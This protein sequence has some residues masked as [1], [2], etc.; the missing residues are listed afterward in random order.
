[1]TGT[2]D[3]QRLEARIRKDLA[4]A[5]WASNEI[6]AYIVAVVQHG[7]LS[8]GSTRWEVKAALAARPALKPVGAPVEEVERWDNAYQL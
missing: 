2:K 5:S 4:E 3:Q 7:P 6:D 1:M 8:R